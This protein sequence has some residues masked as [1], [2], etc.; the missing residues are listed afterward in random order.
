MS[1]DLLFEKREETKTHTQYMHGYYDSVAVFL[2]LVSLCMFSTEICWILS[3]V[4]K[5]NGK[6]RRTDKKHPEVS[7]LC[8]ICHFIA[9]L[10]RFIATFCVHSN[11]CMLYTDKHKHKHREIEN[12]RERERDACMHSSTIFQSE[13][14]VRMSSV[15]YSDPLHTTA[16]L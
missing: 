12:E 13:V 9:F 16:T 4:Q 15:P 6:N 11:Q 5:K 2:L 10:F 14:C 7:I 1:F 3:V 8:R